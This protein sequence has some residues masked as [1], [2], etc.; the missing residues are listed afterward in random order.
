MH[1]CMYV[2]ICMYVCMHVCMYHTCHT[3]FKVFKN[4]FIVISILI[5]NFRR[6]GR[7][8]ISAISGGVSSGISGEPVH[9]DSKV[10]GGDGLE[11]NKIF[12]AQWAC[13]WPK[14]KLG[15]HASLR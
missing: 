12:S 3:Q 5:D 14:H 4:A 2:C 11:S 8:W 7:K 15:H 13:L 1:A 10:R 9:P 6:D